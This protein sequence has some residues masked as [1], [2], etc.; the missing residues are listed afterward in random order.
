MY[1]QPHGA[2]MRFFQRLRWVWT[3]SRIPNPWFQLVVMAAAH[4]RVSSE[5][6]LAPSKEG[7]EVWMQIFPD[8]SIYGNGSVMAPTGVLHPERDTST[9]LSGETVF[10]EINGDK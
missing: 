5:R 6:R 4:A 2:F 8:G 3:T 9:S 1:Y 10:M 7:D